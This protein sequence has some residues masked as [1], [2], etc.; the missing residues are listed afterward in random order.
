V[1]GGRSPRV[2]QGGRW[3]RA[4]RRTGPPAALF[5]R[6]PGASRGTITST[7]G[8]RRALPGID[9]IPYGVHSEWTGAGNRRR[10]R[11]VTGSGRSIGVRAS[12]YLRGQQPDRFPSGRALHG[13]T[14]RDRQNGR[15]GQWCLHPSRGD[16]GSQPLAQQRRHLPGQWR[17]ADAQL[18]RPCNRSLMNRSLSASTSASFPW[19]TSTCTAW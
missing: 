8:T 6:S 10:S 13:R 15:R 17:L 9:E 16:H 14:M 1:V 7:A 5:C 12:A 11:T 19:G 3:H 18:F 4:G 2:I